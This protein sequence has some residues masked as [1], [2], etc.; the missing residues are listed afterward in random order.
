MDN[1]L[2]RI[3]NIARLLS[4]ACLE[5]GYLLVNKSETH[6]TNEA[7][8]INHDVGHHKQL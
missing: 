8:W 2:E 3:P 5:L 4:N 7:S 6:D 1:S